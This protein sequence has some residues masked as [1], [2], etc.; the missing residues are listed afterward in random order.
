MSHVLI[1]DDEPSICW[2]FQEL[3]A[4]DGHAVSIAGSAEEA[5]QIVEDRA[6]DA[7]VM[8]VRLPG[9]DGIS[10]MT[11]LRTRIGQVPII[12]VTAF[13]DLETAV[14]A[15]Q[16]GAVE[17]LS[18][19]FDLEHAARILQRVL[20]QRSS[21]ALPA[22]PLRPERDRALIGSSPAMQRVFKQIAL[23]APTNAPVLITGES[24]TGKE[25]VAQAIHEHSPR[26]DNP[27]I[28]I[29]LGALSEQVIESELFGHVRGA[30]TGAEF[31]RTGL[32]E[33][34]Q[35]GTVLL[36]EIGDIPLRL[37]VKLLRAIER[38]EVTP[39]GDPRPKSTD[40]RVIA[41]THRSLPQLVASGQFRE[42]LLYRLSVFQIDV[43]PLRQRVEDIAV[44]AE[45][46]LGQVAG[47]TADLR[48]TD[49]AVRELC[50]RDWLGNVR[51]LRNAIE[52]AAIVARSGEI[53][54]DHLPVPIG[55]T[56]TVPV[57]I[58]DRIRAEIETWVREQL[59][60]ED[61]TARPDDLYAR[62]LS[63]VDPPLLKAVLAASQNNQVSAAR[64]LGMHRSTLRQKLR[65]RHIMPG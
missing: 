1:V 51:E 37:Q 42:D 62:F 64:L 3:L 28:P 50:A 2:G 7:V 61:Q 5:F 16:S 36:D 45:Y 23:V 4:E 20:G 22:T 41:A 26:K 47:G 40:F 13:G 12:V 15:L 35:G 52:H 43:P 63:L 21:E 8:D 60:V 34:A 31:N 55:L 10:A 27:F 6:P 59:Q 14:R 29:C 39:V 53:R 17:Y 38:R 25:Q 24:G 65:E 32:L 56:R 18:K 19:P 49:G 58:A 30:F 44:L 11:E 9:Q 54:P 46:F 33:L 48:L 57:N